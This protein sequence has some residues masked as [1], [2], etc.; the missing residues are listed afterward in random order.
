MKAKSTVIPALVLFAAAVLM[1]AVVVVLSVVEIADLPHVL[2]FLN[3]ST[4]VLLTGGYLNIRRGRR[5][6]HKGFMLS[7]VAV[8]AAFLVV[9][10]YYHANAGLAR[11]GGT[12]MVRPIYFTILIAH[13]LGAAGIAL[14]VPWTLARALRGRFEAHGKMA[15][16]TLPLWLYVAA[17]GLVVYVM[18][19]QIYPFN[20][21]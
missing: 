11:F 15:R 9:Y 12:G 7:A 5:R 3:G 21:G 8:A 14:M 10:L 13:V 6:A 1:S 18:A 4:V 16:W 17:S 2:A 19:V 20:G